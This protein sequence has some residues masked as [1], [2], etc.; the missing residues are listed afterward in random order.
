MRPDHSL[1]PSLF[2]CHSTC[3]YNCR[4]NSHASLRRPRTRY[5][6]K[7]EPAGHFS[8]RNSSSS[9]AD[10]PIDRELQI[11]FTSQLIFRPR[12]A[13]WPPSALVPSPS[14]CS[15]YHPVNAG[16]A[17]GVMHKR[18]Y[19]KCCPRPSPRCK[20]PFIQRDTYLSYVLYLSTKSRAT[21][22]SL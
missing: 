2:E 16:H 3:P 8:A 12:V 19:I 20:A 22:R 6:F 21:G 13:T 7:R 1:Y 18:K 9:D 15:F 14:S 11:N 17:G 4:E 5:Y 10:R